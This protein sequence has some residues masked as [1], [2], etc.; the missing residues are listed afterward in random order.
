MKY[1]LDTNV[2]SEAR[3][4]P[5]RRDR[6]CHEW[7]CSVPAQDVAISVITL[8]EILAGVIRKERQDPIQGAKLRH[9]YTIDVV[10]GFRERLLPVTAQIAEIEAEIQMPNPRPKADALIA[11][12]ARSHHLILVTRNVSDFD[13]TSTAWL[14]PWTGTQG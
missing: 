7:L 10:E 13:G 1:L 12:T 5:H 4:Q 14:N 11:A 9:W 8:G 2:V 3:K 6:Q